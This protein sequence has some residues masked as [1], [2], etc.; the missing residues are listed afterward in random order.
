MA[1]QK[2]SGYNQCSRVE[3]LMDLWK[4][5]I[6]PKLEARR[7]ENQKAE[8]KIGAYILN[9]MTRLGRPIFERSA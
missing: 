3:N 8:A 9:R 2:K 6:G 4:T 1:W 7:V 5:V